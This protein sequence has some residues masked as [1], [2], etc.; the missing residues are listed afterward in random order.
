MRTTTVTIVLGVC[1]LGTIGWGITAEGEIRELEGNV[2]QQAEQL[3][4]A[5][6]SL[7]QFKESYHEFRKYY[8]EVKM[9]FDQL[10]ATHGQLLEDY[11]QVTED[12]AQSQKKVA[13]LKQEATDWEDAYDALNTY[14]ETVVETVK[15][16]FY[17]HP[18]PQRYGVDDL[19]QYIQRWEWLEGAYVPDSFDCSQMS[20]YLEWKLENEGYH[21]VIVVGETPGEDGYHAWLLVETSAGKYMPVEATASSIVYWENTYFDDYFVYDYKFETIQEALAYSPVEFTWWE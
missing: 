13:T 2:A 10:Q 16:T 6:D 4:Q 8:Y 20:A 11:D 7:N 5:Y 15:F 12:Y 18:P 19:E 3:D 21:T 17:Y 1:L 14:Y 9:E